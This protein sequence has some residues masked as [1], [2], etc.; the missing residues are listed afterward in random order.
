MAWLLSLVLAV[1]LQALLPMSASAQQ[2][3]EPGRVALVIANGSYPEAGIPGA[4]TDGR[5]VASALRDGGFDV[6]AV[7]DAD[8]AALLRALATFTGKLRRGAEAIV[9]YSGHAVQQRGRN[10]LVPLPPQ[11]A[12]QDTI[13]LDALIDALIL[14]RPVSSFVFIDASRNNPWQPAGKGLL[15][16]EPLERIA[17]MFSAAPGRTV[18]D[19]GARASQTV[20]EWLKAIRTPNLDMGAAA[21]RTQDAVARLTRRAQLPWLSS[22]PPA[23]LVVTRPVAV[24]QNNRAVIP[25]LEGTSAPPDAYE[26]AFWETIRNSESAAEYKAYLDA[27][28]NGRFAALARAREQ[29][30]RGKPPAPAASAA[31]APPAPP[32][33]AAAPAAPVAAGPQRDCTGCPELAAIP[34]GTF[35][36]GSNDLYE[37]EKP[38]HPVTVKA[39]LLGT[40]EV[41]YEEWDLCVDQGG[42]NHRP[43]DRGL[44]RGKRPVTDIHWNDANAY[45]SWLSARTGKRYR[46][47]TE[48]EWEYAA[49][50]GTATT[51][52][53]G[54]TMVKERANCNGCNDQPRRSAIAVGQFPPNS[55]GL[56][57]M[58]GNAAEWVADCW[59][60]SYRSTPRDGSAYTVPA[61]RERVLRGGSFNNDPRYLRSAAR[62]KY[63]ADVR[64]YTNGFRVAREP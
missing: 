61:C 32:P 3:A 6:V 7:E 20:E 31:V 53:W 23:G 22:D 44:G 60:E 26:L 13:D 4:L 25:P 9:F 16:V 15:A 46:L 11:N 49:R 36:M 10:F 43:D 21:K 51:Y 19:S 39:F 12:E 17:V 62:F 34:A 24:A 35:Q 29:L 5:A 48:S 28:P 41:S 45:L 50:A 27:Y 64:F 47:P 37:F 58:A 57:D 40:R 2:A 18:T 54:Q 8:R 55:F 30:Y 1:A 38:V 14:A 59:S 52:A 63:D 33:A 42:C 56:Y